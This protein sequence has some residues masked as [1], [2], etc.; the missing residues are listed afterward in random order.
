M[1]AVGSLLATH[2]P[3]FYHRTQR[4]VP[5]TGWWSLKKGAVRPKTENGLLL[6][7]KI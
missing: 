5:A 6:P 4:F 1:L 7:A 2:L 3:A